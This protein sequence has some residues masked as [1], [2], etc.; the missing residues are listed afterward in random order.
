[1]PVKSLENFPIYGTCRKCSTE[2]SLLFQYRPGY[3]ICKANNC[4]DDECERDSGRHI[5]MNAKLEEYSRI[6]GRASGVGQKYLLD[7]S[8]N[9]ILDE[10][11]L[12]IPI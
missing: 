4:W 9:L 10:S 11:G 5:L 8:G 3:F 2:N 6:V 7:E 12:P 1:M